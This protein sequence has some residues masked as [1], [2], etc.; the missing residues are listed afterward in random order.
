MTRSVNT[1]HTEHMLVEHIKEW[2]GSSQIGDDCAQLG[3]GLLAS[4][5]TLVENVHFDLRTTSFYDLGWKSVAVNLSDIAAMAGRPR[6]ILVSLSLPSYVSFNQIREFFCGLT[7]CSQSYRVKVAGGDLTRGN[8]L[9]ISIVVHG[10]DH[11]Q[12]VIKRSGAK[13]G[14]LIVATG[15]FGAARAGLYCLSNG[16][17]GFKYVVERQLTPKP[18]LC[19]SWALVRACSD[20]ASM[21]DAS[22]GLADAL[23]QMAGESNL[24]LVVEKEKVPVHQ[25]TIEVARHAEVDPLDWALAGG[26]DYELVACISESSWKKL[27]SKDLN[28]FKIIGFCREGD[29]NAFLNIAEGKSRPISLEN[30]FQHFDFS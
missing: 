23:V 16:V 15:D 12:G 7:D 3:G 17:E 19:E 18:R 9:S 2:T 8:C 6:S 29:N 4:I 11:E 30:T 5:D 20:E 10:E 21:M 26:E 24:S 1:T 28:P 25:E 27:D 13:D 14:Y 22:D